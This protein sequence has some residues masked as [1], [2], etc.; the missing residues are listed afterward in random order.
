MAKLVALEEFHL[1][2][3]VPGHLPD[4]QVR[5]ARRVLGSKRFQAE[6]L[7]AVRAAL[8]AHP[9]LAQLRSSVSR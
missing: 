4:R 9:S 5:A 6:L 3:K 7:R 1:T 2:L 8:R